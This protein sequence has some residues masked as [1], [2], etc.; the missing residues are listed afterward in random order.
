MNI[1]VDPPQNTDL[2]PPVK[3]QFSSTKDQKAKAFSKDRMKS[4]IT[5]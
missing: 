5:N 2:G 4:R 1:P 3:Q